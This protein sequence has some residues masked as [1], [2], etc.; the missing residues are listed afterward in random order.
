MG[1]FDIFKRRNNAEI[2]TQDKSEKSDKV[3]FKKLDKVKRDQYVLDKCELIL[4]NHKQMDEAKLEYESVTSYLVDIQEIE[5]IPKEQREAINGIAEKIDELMV[6]RKEYHDISEKLTNNQFNRIRMHENEF[7]KAIDRLK[8][9]ESYQST[10]KRDIH[11]LEGEKGMLNY[12]ST[13]LEDE[14][15]KLKKGAVTVPV[16]LVILSMVIYFIQPYIIINLQIVYFVLIFLAALAGVYIFLKMQDNTNEIKRINNN[17]NYAI[18]LLNRTK[19]KYVNETNAVEYAYE[20][21]GVNSAYELNYLWTEYVKA[22]E[23]RERLLRSTDDLD[24]YINRLIHELCKFNV[25]DADV[26]VNQTKALLDDREMVEVRHNLNVRRQKLRNRIEFC[27]NE[28]TRIKN[29]VINLAKTNPEYAEEV[30]E[31][32]SSIDSLGGI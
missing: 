26:W 13:S 29:E 7:P 32:V 2:N 15:E 9:N 10:I 12:Q 5:A 16:I 19:I 24:Y 1:L 17:L 28:M 31:I 14:Q 6:Q 27:S 4:E 20:K 18:V 30:L 25:K 23:E 11:H 3:E 8:A 22:K 21:Y